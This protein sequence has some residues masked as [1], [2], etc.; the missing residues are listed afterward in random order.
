MKYTT[1]AK[2]PDQD[3]RVDTAC[4]R[5]GDRCISRLVLTDGSGGI[6]LFFAN[7]AWTRTLED[8]YTC[9][10]GRTEH[11]KISTVFP[12]PPNPKTR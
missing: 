3:F 4:L 9:G 7:G 8:D 2:T 12:A 11:R 1:S 10:D 5:T 6:L